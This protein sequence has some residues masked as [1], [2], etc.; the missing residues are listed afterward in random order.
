MSL[1]LGH[2]WVIKSLRKVWFVTAYPYFNGTYI[3]LAAELW[4]SVAFLIECSLQQIKVLLYFDQKL[5]LYFVY[6]VS[7]CLSERAMIYICRTWWQRLPTNLPGHECCCQSTHVNELVSLGKQ[8]N[9]LINVFSMTYLYL[10]C[11]I[12]AIATCSFFPY[13]ESYWWLKTNW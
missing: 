1:Q 9:I 3:R 5:L 6:F 8:T 13:M 10:G 11:I 12:T 4:L 2:E 7:F